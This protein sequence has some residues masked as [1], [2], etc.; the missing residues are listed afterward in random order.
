MISRSCTHRLHWKQLIDESAERIAIPKP[1][2]I[3]PGWSALYGRP[4]L[5]AVPE[6]SL[7]A[8][9]NV[10]FTGPDLTRLVYLVTASCCNN[11]VRSHL[12]VAAMPAYDQLDEGVEHR[13][14]RGHRTRGPHKQT[15]GTTTER[16]HDQRGSDNHT[17]RLRG[18]SSRR[19]RTVS[20]PDLGA[21]LPIR[22]P[23]IT[24]NAL[25]FKTQF[26]A[27]LPG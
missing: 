11:L 6:W 10:Q 7:F 25:A 2:R 22:P 20:R 26:Q 27:E 5:V 3:K 18:S 12:L 4:Q 19:A 1:N 24:I 15:A 9:S 13:A 8:S 14:D 17:I 21:T 23:A 16:H